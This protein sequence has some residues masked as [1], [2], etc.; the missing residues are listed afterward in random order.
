VLAVR[1]QPV[2]VRAKGATAWEQWSNAMV[3]GTGI[4]CGAQMADAG[5]SVARRSVYVCTF[6]FGSRSDQ[7]VAQAF[8]LDW[9]WCALVLLIQDLAIFQKPVSTNQRF[10]DSDLT[11]ARVTGA[12]NEKGQRHSK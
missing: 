9:R 6:K 4:E 8:Y 11:C 12:A 5:G 2:L 1:S 3:R 10:R 7:G